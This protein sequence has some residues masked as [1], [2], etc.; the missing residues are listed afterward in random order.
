[1]KELIYTKEGLI[2]LIKNYNFISEVFKIKN[3]IDVFILIEKN[4]SQGFKY[5]LSIAVQKNI[6]WNRKG[7]NYIGIIDRLHDF[8][9]KNSLVAKETAF[10]LPTNPSSITPQ[11]MAQKQSAPANSIKCSSPA[12]PIKPIPK[13]PNR[14]ENCFA[15]DE[16]EKLRRYFQSL[17]KNYLLEPHFC[18]GRNNGGKV[19]V[20]INNEKVF[21]F[22]D[23]T[24]YWKEFIITYFLSIRDKMKAGVPIPESM[25]ILFGENLI[26]RIDI[27]NSF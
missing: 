21:E 20:S 22:H 10:S 15:K 11:R 1:M 19:D 12:T 5:S 23:K 6:V 24:Y 27:H 18:A 17:Y 13:N 8:L 2:S 3:G 9:I 14:D 7:N 4:Q 26:L 16:K 25:S